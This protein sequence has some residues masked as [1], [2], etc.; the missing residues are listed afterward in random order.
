MLTVHKQHLHS[1]LLK[2]S[3]NT[4]YL[5]TASSSS[6][7]VLSRSVFCLVRD[8]LLLMLVSSVVMS[9][10]A[11]RV[12]CSCFSMVVCDVRNGASVRMRGDVL[13]LLGSCSCAS[14]ALRF[15]CSFWVVV[16]DLRDILLAFPLFFVF[17]LREDLRTC[18]DLLELTP[19][20]PFVLSEDLRTKPL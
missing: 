13:V 3:F 17:L 6:S 9:S 5:K 12:T 7:S 1:T 20:V 15:T 2:S 8:D 10:L 4:V 11:L 18:D 14:C 16:S 19:S